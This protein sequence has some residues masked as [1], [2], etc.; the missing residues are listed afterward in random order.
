MERDIT[1]QPFPEYNIPVDVNRE[2][3]G[4]VDSGIHSPSSVLHE[5]N[6]GVYGDGHE[7][8]VD[9]SEHEQVGGAP[10]MVNEEVI[11]KQEVITLN[12]N[13]DVKKNLG[14][15]CVVQAQGESKLV[16]SVQSNLEKMKLVQKL[17]NE[18]ACFKGWSSELQK[19][20]LVELDRCKVELVTEKTIKDTLLL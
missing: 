19:I 15:D 12:R 4:S 14:S 5:H 16:V 20:P 2:D 7:H 17:F 9:V 13:M 18:S 10:A 1:S 11:Y 6:T 3:N 8:D